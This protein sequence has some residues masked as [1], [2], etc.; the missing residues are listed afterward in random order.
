MT[1]LAEQPS[2]SKPIRRASSRSTPGRS[3]SPPPRR[4]TPTHRSTAQRRQSPNAQTLPTGIAPP[5]EDAVPSSKNRRPETPVDPNAVTQ[6]PPSPVRAIAR[7]GLT[8]PPYSGSPP[9]SG[10]QSRPT[11]GWGSDEYPAGAAGKLGMAGAVDSQRTTGRPY[12]LVAT[13][14][15]TLVRRL[16][17]WL[18]ATAELVVLSSLSELV[19]DLEAFGKARIAIV[20]DCRRPSVRP[21]A[22]AALADELPDNVSVVLW[23]ASPEQERGVL[24]VSPS[25]NRWIVLHGDTRP[26]ELAARCADIVG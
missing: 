17:P 15:E 20:I 21:T 7:I 19:K 9:L 24:A 1:G 26:K 18:D 16:T 22:I 23:G 10:T 12:V 11:T 14:D 4:I 25:V 5:T 2:S 3:I 13:S 6:P 8:P